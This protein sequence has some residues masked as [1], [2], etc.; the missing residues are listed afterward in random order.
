M[1]SNVAWVRID[2]FSGVKSSGVVSPDAFMRFELEAEELEFL[3]SCFFMCR[4]KLF[5]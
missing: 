3:R 2:E 1:T 5:C 4:F